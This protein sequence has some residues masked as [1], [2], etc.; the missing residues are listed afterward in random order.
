MFVCGVAWAKLQ[1]SKKQV[2][3]AGSALNAIMLADDERENA[4]AIVN[5]WR[6]AHSYPLQVFK[7]TLKNRASSV[8][9][10]ALVAQRIKRIPAIQLKLGLNR[11]MKLSS[12]QDIGGCR[13]ILSTVGLA[14]KLARIYEEAS[15]RNRRRGGLFLW[16]K[17]YIQSPKPSGYRGIHLV[18]EYVSDSRR[19]AHFNGRK[20]EI[21][22]RSK[23]QH[24]W[25]TAVETVS[26]FTGQALKSNIGEQSWKDFFLIVAGVFAFQEK[27]PPVPNA[28]TE[29]IPLIRE[30]T[31]YKEHIG[32]LSSFTVAVSEMKTK[33]G[34]F[35]LLV[36][37][38]ESRKVT[39]TPFRKDE[40]VLAQE[41]Y[42]EVEKEIEAA[43]SKGPL[44]KQAVLVSVDS[45]SGL[46]KAYPNYFLDI[47]DFFDALSKFT[48]R[49]KQHLEE[50]SSPTQ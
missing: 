44:V 28:P 20:I 16:K 10:G 7:M 39:V 42:L 4:L 1:F 3:R 5:N 13:A 17:D 32:M 27:R 2:D 9:R 11:T 15:A 45:L 30:L 22:I 36:L 37:D 8:E 47:G 23:L 31:K 38:P 35:Y 33:Q 46:R 12:M 21:Q 25:A 50:L 43:V 40:A 26:I 49:V 24:A 19:L 48:E 18:Y 41:R 34:Y 14:E 6:S 29:I